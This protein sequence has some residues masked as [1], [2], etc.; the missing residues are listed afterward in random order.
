MIG[1][2]A[3]FVE[4]HFVETCATRHLAQRTNLDTFGVHVDDEAAETFVLGQTW[5]G[6]ADDLADVTELGTRCP[7]LLTGDHPF[8]AVAL[9][10]R[11]YRSEVA[12]CAGFGEQLASDDVAAPQRT[13]VALLGR[14]RGMSED[15]RR[16][17]AETDLEHTQT[18]C[19]VLALDGAVSTLVCRREARA[20]VLG[21]SGDPA[22]SV[23]ETRRLPLFGLTDDFHF[24]VA[25][26]FFEHRHVVGALAPHECALTFLLLGVLIE[27]CSC[28]VGELFD[29]DRGRH[30]DHRTPRTTVC[31][32]ASP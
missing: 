13:Q 21:W 18:R 20:A 24:R 25:I 30:G 32:W 22:E 29:G 3:H 27:E 31:A 7:H 11:L 17:H 6:A 5:I 14:W 1:W 28:L 15:R 2:N 4:E 26:A 12:P 19:A 9:G 23:V 16:H 10:L 8:V